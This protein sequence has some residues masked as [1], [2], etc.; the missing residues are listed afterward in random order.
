MRH[1][2]K[3]NFY[4]KG[5]SFVI[6]LLILLMT[7]SLTGCGTD[8]TDLETDGGKDTRIITDCA[9]RE[10]AVPVN[11]QRIAC[12]CPEAGYALAMYGKGDKIVATTD[13]MQRDVLLMEMYPRLKGL[14]IPKKGG[15]INVEELLRIKADLIFVKED[16]I[17]NEAEMEKLQLAKVPVVVVKFTSMDDQQFAMEMIAKIVGTEEESKEYQQFYQEQISM[18][19][20]RTANIPD[21]ERARVYHST[22]EATRTDTAGT[23]AADWTKAAGVINVSVDQD[24]KFID[25]DHYASLEQILLWDPDYILANNPDVVGYI[26]TNEQWKSLK[27]VKNQQVLP[28]PVGISRWGHENSLETPLAAIWTAKTVYPDLFTDVDMTDIIQDFYLTFFDWQLDEATI[29]RI[30]TSQ[31]MREAKG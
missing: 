12:T 18:V 21:E 22:Q 24:L 8:Q 9:G 20:D 7:F 15:A 27:A 6:L 31:G 4:S 29:Q 25:G 30:L 5:Q 26:M 16:T 19:Q 2:M 17:S 13:G 1:R 28:L 10:V 14:S 11:P 3:G 23:L